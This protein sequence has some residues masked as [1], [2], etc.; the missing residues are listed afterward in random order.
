MAKKPKKAVAT[1]GDRSLSTNRRA[2]HNYEIM[3]RYEAG[4]VLT[5]SEIKSLRGG[6][7]DFTDAYARPDGRELWLLNTHIPHYGP[8]SIYN[9][10]PDRPRKLLLHRAQIVELGSQ[11]AQKGLTIVP[12]RIYIRNHVAKVELGLARGKRQYDKRQTLIER[13]MDRDAQRAVRT[14]RS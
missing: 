10:D 5:G 8:A 2:F 7:I 3:E 11:V 14:A 6:R 4:L 1:N 9:H 12:L 13:D